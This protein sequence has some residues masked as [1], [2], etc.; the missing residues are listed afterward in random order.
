MSDIERARNSL[1][2]KLS[3]MGYVHPEST[4]S[5]SGDGYK[6]YNKEG[7]STY[8][9]QDYNRYA[10]FDTKQSGDVQKTDI[11]PSCETKA[12]Y[13]CDCE[14]GDMMCTNGHMWYVQKD[15]KVIVGD[16]HKD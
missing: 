14:F 4:N 5:N 6:M 9:S 11:C 2:A 8:V 16:P 7:E 1:D 12:L 13:S 10:T 15:G 3:E